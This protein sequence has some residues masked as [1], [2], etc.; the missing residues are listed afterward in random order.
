MPS[1]KIVKNQLPPK[2]KPKTGTS[3]KTREQKLDLSKERL[4]A[5]ALSP[6]GS[7]IAAEATALKAARDS[8]MARSQEVTE[9]KAALDK[10]ERELRL[11]EADH[12]TAIEVYAYRAGIIAKDDP[13]VLQSLGVEALTTQRAPRDEGPAD[14]PANLRVVPGADSGSAIMK[15]SR[16]DGAAAFLAQ[17]KLESQA[18][19]APATDWFPSDG[20][21]TKKVEWTIDNLPPAAHLRG[22]VRAI[23]AEVGPWSEEALGRAR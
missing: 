1:N 17:Y 9:I 2:V 14:M 15:W 3:R 11:A 16:P 4:A 7:E 22:R 5:Q 23:G 13:I 12:D 18:A 8:V 6:A 19:D 10:K 21:A 20:F